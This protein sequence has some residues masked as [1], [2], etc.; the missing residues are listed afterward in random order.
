MEHPP[1]ERD[2]VSQWFKIFQAPTAEEMALFDEPLLRDVGL[3]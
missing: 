2:L 1:I 3:G